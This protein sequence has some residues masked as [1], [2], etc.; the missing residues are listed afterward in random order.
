MRVHRDIA[1]VKKILKQKVPDFKTLRKL[2]DDKHNQKVIETEQGEI[3]IARRPIDNV[4][5]VAQYGPCINCRV[6]ATKG[7]K[8]ALQV[9]Y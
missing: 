9:M 7:F 3:L 8:S 6:D 2:G 1:E 5:H 4:L